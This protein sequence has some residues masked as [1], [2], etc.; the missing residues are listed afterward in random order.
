MSKIVRSASI[1][2]AMVLFCQSVRAQPGPIIAKA[3]VGWLLSVVLQPAAQ[4]ANEEISQQVRQ[5]TTGALRTAS[6]KLA[7]SLN[8]P[9]A[10][11]VDRIQIATGLSACYIQLGEVDKAISFANQARVYL[12]NLNESEIK[13]ADIE[14]LKIAATSL[15]AFNT[16]YDTVNLAGQIRKIMVSNARRLS[17]TPPD[18]PDIEIGSI[19]GPVVYINPASRGLQIYSQHDKCFIGLRY[20]PSELQ[21]EPKYRAVGYLWQVTVNNGKITSAF[22]SGSE[23][24]K[25]KE[26]VSMMRNHW[27]AASKG[28]G[29][30]FLTDF[31]P[32]HPC[33]TS[34]TAIVTDPYLLKGREPQDY[35]ESTFRVA[36]IDQHA[37]VVVADYSSI[38]S[39][40]GF[41][42]YEIDQDSPQGGPWKICRSQNVP[43]P[44]F[45]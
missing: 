10:S 1:A 30:K 15:S 7:G 31:S 3:V 16:D 13:V 24:P 35:P 28:D 41:F 23:D 26:V 4:A 21:I 2:I 5:G 25:I 44:I 22:C 19:Y 14:K 37:V 33:L 40:S 17:V 38:Y 36:S 12:H 11:S 27:S 6:D 34:P 45:E 9:R 32:S 43:R 39:G 42:L 20:D 8:I 18:L 29:E